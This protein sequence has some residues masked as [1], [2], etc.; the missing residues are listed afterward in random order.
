MFWNNQP[1]H[2]NWSGHP[3]DLNR[4]IVKFSDRDFWTIG[5]SFEGTQIFGATGSGKTS[6]SG[7][8]IATTFLQAGYGGLVLTAKKDERATWE[9]YCAM[10]GCSDHLLIISPQSG[11]TFNFLDYELNRP[12]VGAG[13]TENLV[14]LFTEI[15][16]VAEDKGGRGANS[17]EYWSRTLKQL[18]RNTIDLLTLSQNTLSV[19]DM[20]KVIT[21]APMDFEDIQSETWRDESFCFQKIR[22]GEA[23]THSYSR[24][25]DFEITARYW[26]SEFPGLAEKTRSIIV[27]SFTS[28]ADSFL[29]GVLRDMF[30]TETNFLPEMTEEG[31][32]ILIDLPVKEYG[33]IGR[34]AQVLFKYIWQQT[35]ERRI[36]TQNSRPVFLWA[37]ESQFFISKY[38]QVFQTTARSSRAATVYLTQNLP[39]YL[40]TLG[41]RDIVDSFLGNLQTKIFHSN[42][43][44]VTNEWAANIFAK[45]WQTRTSQNQSINRDG[46]WFFS[47]VT[48]KSSS[49]NSSESLEYTVLPYEF[50]KLRK[51]GHHNNLKVDA[52][53]FQG[54]RIWQSSGANYILT[55]F[56]QT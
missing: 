20:Y 11:F 13:L 28:M 48:G 37:D 52:Y 40:T 35:I 42:G 36:I 17:E 44:A 14:N 8:T 10:T 19:M 32:I 56:S 12:G 41:N 33:D 25:Q 55:S 18:L 54:G 16:E 45:N 34:Y 4:P 2:Q 23:R 50:T 3:F 47:K 1:S 6:G 15:M 5:D 39:N 26:L 51:G 30:C 43:D 46:D 24:E 29:R 27:S 49:I 22:E 53:I 7:Q 21:S 31:V 9:R 38:D